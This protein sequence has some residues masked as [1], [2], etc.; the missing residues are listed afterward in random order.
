MSDIEQD[1]DPNLDAEVPEVATDIAKPALNLLNFLGG[2]PAADTATPGPSE[3]P[4][5]RAPR[6]RKSLADGDAKQTRLGAG[7]RPVKVQ[8]DVPVEEDIDMN[9]ATAGPS[10]PDSSE[11]KKLGRKGKKRV[12]DDED[13]EIKA[14]AKAAK[15]KK[16]ATNPKA[17]VT[18]G[19]KKKDAE[20]VSDISNEGETVRGQLLCLKPTISTETKPQSKPV[21]RSGRKTA[22]RKSTATSASR[23]ASPHTNSI[24]TAIHIPD[25]PDQVMISKL[26]VSKRRKLEAM[27]DEDSAIVLDT[28]FDDD[29]GIEILQKASRSVSP[30]KET[31]KATSVFAAGQGRHVHPFFGPKSK[32]RGTSATRTESRAESIIDQD[33]DNPDVQQSHVIHTIPE[34]PKPIRKEAKHPDRATHVFFKSKGKASDAGE[35]VLEMGRKAVLGEPVAPPLV[36]KSGWGKG[37]VESRLCAARFPTQEEQA[38]HM[39]P[40]REV[41]SGMSVRRGG[42]D[43]PRRERKR[44]QTEKS[45]ESSFWRR[46]Y[47]KEE[48]T[49]SHSPAPELT[50]LNGVV[51]NDQAYKE[52]AAVQALSAKREQATPYSTRLWTD[53]YRP[54]DS[55]QVLGNEI[56]SNYL[57]RWMKELA[58]GKEAKHVPGG[59]EKPSAEV[60][61]KKRKIMRKVKKTRRKKEKEDDW[62]VDD[63]L[64]PIDDYLSADGTDTTGSVTDDENGNAVDISLGPPIYPTFSSRLAN[65][66]LLQGPHGCGKTAAVYAAAAELGWEVFEVNAG[67]KRS[68]AQLS[69]L[70]GEVG[71][72]H[73]V[74]RSAH[75]AQDVLPAKTVKPSEGSKEPRRNALFQAFAKANGKQPSSSST[76]SALSVSTAGQSDDTQS[77]PFITPSAH[78]PVVDENG[79]NPA[80]TVNFGFLDGKGDGG[81]EGRS[82]RQSLILFEEV[83]ILYEEDQGFWP[84]VVELIAGSKRPVVMTCNGKP[85]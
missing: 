84:Q 2:R 17:T 21:S 5:K 23:I 38:C 59:S 43:M 26:P 1:I 81:A 54:T 77:N 51:A 83:D 39:K 7:L 63:T 55:S 40:V 49:S 35:A 12:V 68:G 47:P 48:H 16:P 10:Q 30:N 29:D 42:L 61:P 27:N 82:I 52:N 9:A 85:D 36:G 76:K 34:T 14:M 8:P 3:A 79:A 69:A 57:A 70:V 25:S 31:R 20:G 78:D 58:L 44:S 15:Q 74:G 13:R 41:D 33:D 73:M 28:S 46:L 72:N 64:D 37:D 75:A 18:K 53:K 80:E 62:I 71:R 60:T 32:S 45:A 22:K 6:Q 24:D 66:I 67:A 65:S 50:A 19:S 11:Q 56:P 4:K